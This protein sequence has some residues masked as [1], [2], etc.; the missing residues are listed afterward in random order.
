MMI[1]QE[2]KFFFQ[3]QKAHKFI[4]S[5]SMIIKLNF[6]EKLIENLTC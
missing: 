6:L 4:I 5:S 1:S 3:E 2:R